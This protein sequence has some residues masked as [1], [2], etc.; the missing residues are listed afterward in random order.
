MECVADVQTDSGKSG[1]AVLRRSQ[2]EDGLFF[3]LL[4][5]SLSLFLSLRSFLFSSETTCLPSLGTMP[6]MG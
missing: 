5:L 2:D 6:S 1:A 3:F 4:V